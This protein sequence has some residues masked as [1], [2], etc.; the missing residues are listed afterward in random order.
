LTNDLISR[1]WSNAITSENIPLEDASVRLW[2][3]RA[4]ALPLGKLPKLLLGLGDLYRCAARK[5]EE[6]V[7]MAFAACKDG[8]Q[9]G[10]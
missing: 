7:A 5:K 1:A 3:V 6:E 4:K 2:E 8:A 10:G 9:S